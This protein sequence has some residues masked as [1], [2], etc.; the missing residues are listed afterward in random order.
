MDVVGIAGGFAEWANSLIITWGYLGL[1]LVEVIG[2]MSIFFP[3]PAFA[4]NFFLG[5]MPG[6]NP[7]IV[8]MVAGL[9]SAIGEMTSYILGRGGRRIVNKK[10][11][12]LLNKARK[13]IETHGAFVII[14]LFAATP[15]PFDIIGILAG[16]MNYNIKRF[17]LATLT[18]KTLAGLILAWAGYY[19]VGWILTVFGFC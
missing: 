6:F 16:M 17:F 15:L 12:K 9:G 2:S 14:V 10:H 7:W 13:W 3:V 18:G 11:L 5:G 8:G 4:V 19:S 1:F